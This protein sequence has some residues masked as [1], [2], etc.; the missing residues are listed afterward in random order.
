[1]GSAPMLSVVVPAYN[2]RKYIR[3]TALSALN[4][5][6]RDL[7]LIIV[8]DGST[9]DTLQVISVLADELRDPRLIIID[10]PNRG[11]SSARNTGIERARGRYIGLLDNDDLWHPEKAE[12]QI[13]AMEADSTI[14]MTFS[15]SE[16]IDEQEKPFWM[17]VPKKSEPTCRDSIR[18]CQLGN[19]SN[20]I[21]RR[22]CFE[23]AGMFDVELSECADYEMWCRVA[24][25]SG[26]RTVLVP[27]PLTIYRIHP[28]SMSFNLSFTEDA[29]RTMLKLRALMPDIPWYVFREGHAEHYVIQARRFAYRNPPLARRYFRS[30][31]WICPWLFFYDPRSSL[32]V[33]ASLL[34]PKAVWAKLLAVKHALMGTGIDRAVQACTVMPRND[35]KP[36]D[37]PGR[38]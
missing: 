29:D 26:L 36:L 18:D 32:S 22:E 11:V 1:M 7:E 15:Y 12:R 3:A 10:G 30:A 2:C 35:P 33:F 21:L 8:N 16:C 5:T 23:R 13:A 31:L 38:N 6:L 27:R 9:D 37:A 28:D 14:G 19:G 34:L 24:Y 25:L 20:P 17:L 4:Q